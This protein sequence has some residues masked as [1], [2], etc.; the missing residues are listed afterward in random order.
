MGERENT[1]LAISAV[2]HLVVLAVLAVVW[3]FG[4]MSTKSASTP[5]IAVDMI[6]DSELSQIMA[7]VKNAPQ[8]PAPKPIVDK[9]GEASPPVKDPTP[10]VSDKPE[11]APSAAAP[12]PPPPEAKP[13]EAKPDKAEPKVDEIAEALKR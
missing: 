6:S 3:L 10:K 7:G 5:V 9:I 11:I 8:A 13:A 2:G 4:L 12:P 1:G